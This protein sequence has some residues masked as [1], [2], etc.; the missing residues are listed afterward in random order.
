MIIESDRVTNAVRYPYE[1]IDK[2]GQ[3]WGTFDTVQRAADFAKRHLPD[4]SQ[5]DGGWDVRRV[6]QV[7]AD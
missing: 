3:S 7:R 4:Q 2:D 1:L 6:P 5:G